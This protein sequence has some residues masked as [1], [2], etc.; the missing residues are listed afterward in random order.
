MCSIYSFPM[1]LVKFSENGSPLSVN[2]HLGG[3]HYKMTCCNLN[4]IDSAIFEEALY[5]KGHLL[6]VTHM[7]RCSLPW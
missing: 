5:I 3:L 7:R 6:N 4:C 1:N 2:N